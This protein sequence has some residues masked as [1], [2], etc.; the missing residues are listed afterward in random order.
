MLFSNIN[1]QLRVYL[2]NYTI[3]KRAV[4]CDHEEWQGWLF[5]VCSEAS[6][7]AKLRV[8]C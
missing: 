4:D 8:G 1:N 2:A 5:R 6:F 7:P 3:L